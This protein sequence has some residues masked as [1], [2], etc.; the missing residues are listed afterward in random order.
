M[1]EGLTDR[2]EG[3]LV[4]L[5]PLR[6]EH[7]DGLR[8]ASMSPDIWQWL[9]HVGSS[10]EHF[11]GWLDW[12]LDLQEQGEEGVFATI[13]R[14]SGDPVGSTRYLNLRPEHRGLEI[15]FTWLAPHMWRTGANVEAKLLMLTHAFET[16]SCLRVEFKA[17]ARNER[18]RA[19]LEALPAQFEGILR[20][21]MVM[22]DVGLRDSAYFSVIDEEWPQV[23]ANLEA[24]LARR[25]SV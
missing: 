10:D 22:P 19:A 3:S 17:D 9:P 23:K 21:H 7:R 4:T 2:L 14:A 25:A 5:E 24:R 13:D 11:D 6:A 12:S 20:S 15:G 18:S 16:L 1:W 8:A